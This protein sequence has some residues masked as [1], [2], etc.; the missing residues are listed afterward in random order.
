MKER[1]PTIPSRRETW[2]IKKKDREKVQV[3][4]TKFLRHLADS[5]GYGQNTFGGK[6]ETA[7][8]ST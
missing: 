7:H 6:E 4:E 5:T 3:A 2:F 1:K 8:H